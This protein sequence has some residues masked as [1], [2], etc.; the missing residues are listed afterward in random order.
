MF[1]LLLFSSNT[2][3]MA[4]NGVRVTGEVIDEKNEALPGVNVV[5]LGKT[6]GTIT[7]LKGKFSVL[8]PDEKSILVFTFIGFETKNIIVGSNTNLSVKMKEDT[9]LLDEVVVVG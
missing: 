3:V 7:D 5:V 6:M 1:C 8:V 9:K 4:Q 2:F